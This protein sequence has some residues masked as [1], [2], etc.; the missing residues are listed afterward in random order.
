MNVSLFVAQLVAQHPV[1]L[2]WAAGIGAAYVGLSALFN[3]A[4]AV[5]KAAGKGDSKAAAFCTHA[6]VW[7]ADLH[8]AWEK[9]KGVFLP[10]VGPAAVVAIAAG[11][12]LLSPAPARAQVD[13]NTPG[14]CAGLSQLHCGVPV[15]FLSVS[16]FKTVAFDFSPET[17]YGADYHFKKWDLG[18][19]LLFGG[20]VNTLGQN[21]FL[22]T[23][24]VFAALGDA[25]GAFH[26]VAIGP[27]IDAFNY[28]SSGFKAW[29]W[30]GNFR[31]GVTFSPDLVELVS[32]L[33]KPAR[34]TR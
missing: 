30:A 4:L 16:P 5:L 11:V 23:L 28:Q 22:G 13:D 1:L 7:L 21:G 6:L 19:A 17:G 10:K 18:A 9:Y 8:Q 29:T 34:T 20:V 26:G 32:T 24:A 27:L 12:L 2:K 14:G 25:F 15:S 3:A 33:F 31:V